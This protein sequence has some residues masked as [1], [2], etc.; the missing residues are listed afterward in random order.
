VDRPA[1]DPGAAGDPH[2]DPVE[3]RRTIRKLLELRPSLVC[4][5]H[6]PPLREIEK[7]ERLVERLP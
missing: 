6:G 1:A 3:N 7:L 5:G 4:V 2:L